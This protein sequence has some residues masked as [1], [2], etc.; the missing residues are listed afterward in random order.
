LI[1][2]D[3]AQVRKNARPIIF[4]F[5]LK[6]LD[7]RDFSHVSNTKKKDNRVPQYKTLWKEGKRIIRIQYYLIIISDNMCHVWL[8]FQERIIADGNK[9]EIENTS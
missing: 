2:A 9:L 8:H 6:I 7:A 4:S 1:P 5:S 3:D